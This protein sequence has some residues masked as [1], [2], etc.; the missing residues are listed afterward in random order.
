LLATF[1]NNRS[2]G[3]GLPTRA[4]RLL[5]KCYENDTI[6]VLKQQS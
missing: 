2:F 6:C 5:H 3:M 4:S 1:P